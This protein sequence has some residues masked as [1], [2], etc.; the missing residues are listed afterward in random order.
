MSI[1]VD[2]RTTTSASEANAYTMMPLNYRI[3]R[4]DGHA[5]YKQ[6]NHNIVKYFNNENNSKYAQTYG[7]FLSLQ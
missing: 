7:E 5:N 3:Y 4:V 2:S 1:R 6:K